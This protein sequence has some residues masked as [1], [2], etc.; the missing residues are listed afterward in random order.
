MPLSCQDGDRAG[1][2]HTIA[3]ALNEALKKRAEGS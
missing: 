1:W 2:H 3:R